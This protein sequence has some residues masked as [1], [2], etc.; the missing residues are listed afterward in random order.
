MYF[1]TLEPTHLQYILNL[2][3]SGQKVGILLISFS[4]YEVI[5]RVIIQIAQL[6]NPS[7]C[8]L[9]EYRRFICTQDIS[10]KIY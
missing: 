9:P 6:S 1:F 8:S 5:V 4:L 7:K 3:F 2:D 10:L